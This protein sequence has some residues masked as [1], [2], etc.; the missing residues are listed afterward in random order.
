M[1]TGNRGFTLIEVLLALLIGGLVLSSLYG[2]FTPISR[3]S[4]QLE[5]EGEQYH[6]VRVLF[7]R[8]SGE[9]GSLRLDAVDT[10]KVLQAGKDDEGLPYLEFN[11]SF[12]SPGAERYGSIARV[13]YELRSDADAMTLYRSEELLLAELS[14]EEG[15]EFISGIDN[16]SMRFYNGS[17]WLEQWN[18]SKLPEMVELYFEI[19]DE[20]QVI[21][22]RSSFVLPGGAG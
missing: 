11:T 8:L 13:R 6:R 17:K 1:K 10:R 19:G 2:I 12:V 14:A 15:L 16:A 22:F 3:I 21:P 5:Q 9:L 20:G 18:G 7:D 4:R